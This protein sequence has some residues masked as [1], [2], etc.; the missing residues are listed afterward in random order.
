MRGHIYRRLADEIE[1]RVPG[2]VR[3]EPLTAKP[4][5]PMNGTGETPSS[6]SGQPPP[7]GMGAMFTVTPYEMHCSLVSTIVPPNDWRYNSAPAQA[8]IRRQMQA[9]VDHGVW[10][11][12]S[13]CEASSVPEPAEFVGGKLLISITCAE[14]LGSTQDP[15]QAQWKARFV[16]TGKY[17]S[18]SKGRK[19]YEF[20][21]PFAM[22]IDLASVRAVVYYGAQYGCVMQAD[23]QTAYLLA[24]LGGPPTWIRLPRW[25]LPPAARAMK[26]LVLK[27]SRALY[28]HPRSGGDWDQ[29]LGRILKGRG[30]TPVEGVLSLW[31]S[32]CKKCALAVYVDDL[33]CGGPKESVL[34]LRSSTSFLERST[35][36]EDTAMR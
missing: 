28:G 17:I 29:H 6:S 16:C 32:P 14:S 1:E 31:V 19:V 5:A 20:D 7:S 36:L 11:P 30:W 33:L 27:L 23:V 35:S 21:S 24:K 4:L 22:P 13:L 15:D 3:S 12:A 2:E 8:A 10:D 9:M 25:A 18:D 34:R 26:D